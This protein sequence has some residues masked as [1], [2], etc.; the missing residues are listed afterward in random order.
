MT[1]RRA[2]VAL[3]EGGYF[4]SRARARAAIEA[5]HV[6]IDGQ[7]IKKPSKKISLD[8]NITAKAAHPY[9]SRGGV[10][11]THALEQFNIDVSGK[12][13]LDVGA[14]TGGFCDVLVRAGASKIYAV[15]VGTDQLHSAMRAEPKV[16]SLE[17]TDAR[18]LSRAQIPDDI[19]CVVCDASF[20]S[21]MK[22][23]ERPLSLAKAGAVLITLVKP[24]FEV[25]KS[26]LGRGGIVTD[27]GLADDALLM[28]QNW[29]T[30]QG[31]TVK[32]SIPSP[33]KGGSGNREFLLYALKQD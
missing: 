22:V 18:T 19:D 14:S 7:V 3:V 9:V 11:M 15:D 27:Q 32:A 31:W 23:L 2:D 8:A 12:V 25:G 1:L 17:Q 10:K 16:I 4:E 29:V 20:I 13:C 33:I 26:G 21:A 28:V 30:E 24:Q 5:G 6:S